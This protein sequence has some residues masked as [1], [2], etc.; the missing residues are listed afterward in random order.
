MLILL[1]DNEQG[2]EM[3]TLSKLIELNNTNKHVY[4]V[5]FVTPKEI[6]ERIGMSEIPPRT[7]FFATWGAATSASIG[8]AGTSTV[9]QVAASEAIQQC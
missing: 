5:V 9:T 8:W 7:E 4:K 1:I 6:T 2:K 3:I